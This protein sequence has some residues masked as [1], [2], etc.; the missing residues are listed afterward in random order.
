MAKNEKT[1]GTLFSE[2]FKNE[3]IGEEK[4]LIFDIFCRTYFRT[5]QNLKT[6]F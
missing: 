5:P 1:E 4:K 6:Y 2:T 3:E